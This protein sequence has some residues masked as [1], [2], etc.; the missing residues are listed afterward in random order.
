MH[1]FIPGQRCISDAELQ[2]GLGTVLTVEFRTLTVLFL[3][4]GETRT[5]AKQSA[6]LTR[7]AFE[8][9]DTITT[10][11]GCKIKVQEVL[12]VNGLLSYVGLDE[13]GTLTDVEESQLDNFLK[14]NRPSERLFNGQIDHDKWFE[15]R[16]QSL[17]HRHRLLHSELYGLTGCR[18][19]LIAHQL[20]IAH[21][22]AN[23]F[24]PRV[25]LADEVGLG[26]TIEAGLILHNQLL[27]ERARRVLIV[28]PETLVHQWLVEMLRRFN[29]HFKIFDE[30]R[31][32]SLQEDINEGRNPFHSE[33]LVLCSLGFLRSNADC[34]EYAM[35]GEWDL[36]VVDEAHHLQWSPEEP[37]IEYEIIEQLA[38]VTEGVLLLTATPEQLGKESHFARLRLLDPDRFHSFDQFIEEEASY[39]P[40]AQVVEDLLSGKP[41]TDQDIATIKQTFSEGDNEA[42]FKALVEGNDSGGVDA[43]DE[44]QSTSSTLTLGKRKKL[45]IAK[46]KSTADSSAGKNQARLELVEHLLDR[47]GTGRVLF[48]NTRAAV[49]GFPER[50]VFACPL[51]APA[52]YVNSKVDEA[53]LLLTPEVNLKKGVAS[54]EWTTCDPRMDWLVNQLTELSTEK[55][56]VIAAHADT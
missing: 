49:K 2:M 41:L 42:L 56:L 54:Q 1:E 4:T 12:E 44:V 25:L 24:A 28:V 9:G 45:G 38:K 47:H 13:A 23:R 10:H 22:V 53:A 16:Y 52:V 50:K 17:Q 55:I 37:S 14:L 35:D 46:S 6:P 26:K 33:Q 34:F 51:P 30:Q 3:A 19:S 40:I 18:T 36:L 7:V 39:E 15:L 29:L 21:E 48:R 20:Y 8:V 43:A 32:Q 27:T 31:W 11:D 5:Y